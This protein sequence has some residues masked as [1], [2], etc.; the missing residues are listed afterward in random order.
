[1]KKA[2]HKHSDMQGQFPIEANFKNLV[3]T[4]RRGKVYTWRHIF[5]NLYLHLTDLINVVFSTSKSKIYPL[6]L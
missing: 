6:T 2:C 4:H 1:M 5:V 3:R